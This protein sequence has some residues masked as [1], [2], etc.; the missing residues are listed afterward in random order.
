MDRQTHR[1][2]E[3]GGPTHI[4][5]PH[6]HLSPATSSKPTT[7][8]RGTPPPPAASPAMKAGYTS[9]SLSSSTSPYRTVIDNMLKF[10]Q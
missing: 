6:P 2:Q 3:T 1:G 4:P 5:S 7:Q 10:D 9:S 8:Y